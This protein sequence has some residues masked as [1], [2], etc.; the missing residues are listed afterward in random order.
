MS[1]IVTAFLSLSAYA[2]PNPIQE[3]K[4]RWDFNK[5]C[6]ARCTKD[7]FTY[8]AKIY[9]PTG[10]E[11]GAR[12]FVIAVVEESRKHWPADAAPGLT[13]TV[14]EKSGNLLVQV[15]GTGCRKNGKTVALQG[16]L[17]MVR[18]HLECARG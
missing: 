16:H 3:F 1:V 10:D 11:T 17:D 14:E 18:P 2:A 12:E 5:A 9:R 7:L 15:P 4:D 13:Y 6:D 8:L